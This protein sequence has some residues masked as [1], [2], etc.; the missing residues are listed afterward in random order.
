M[1]NH[2]SRDSWLKK[3]SAMFLLAALGL[4]ACFLV[5]NKHFVGE[6]DGVHQHFTTLAF[7]REIFQDL[8]SGRGFEMVN[9]QIGQG[10]DTIGTLSYYGLADP[11][12]WIAALFP[13]NMLEYAFA[14]S[15]KITPKTIIQIT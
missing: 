14:S 8:I 9:L 11:L 3:Y 10:L 7:I 15:P 13:A 12:N 5:Q 4:L 1:K 6:L 2:C